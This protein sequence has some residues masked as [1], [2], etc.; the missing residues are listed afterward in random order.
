MKLTTAIA[1]SLELPSGKTGQIK[2][3][4]IVWDDD[5]PGFGVRL[6]AGRNGKV[7]R[8]W[9]YQYDFA[10]RTRRITIGNVNAIG[11]E[12]ARKIAGQHHADVRRGQDPVAEKAKSLARSG[13]IFADVLKTFL[14]VKK[15]TNR[16]GTYNMTRL[17]LNEPCKLLHPMSLNDIKRRHVAAILTTFAARGTKSA[18]NHVRGKLNTF[19]NWAITQGLIE[20][21]PVQG[22]EKKEASER[23]RVLSVAELVAVWRALEDMTNYEYALGLLISTGGYGH[24]HLVDDLVDYRDIV[25]MLMLTAARRSEISELPW[26]EVRTEESFID[27]GLPVAGP[28]LVLP[29]KRTKNE[30]KFIMHLSKPAQVVLQRHPRR[31]DNDQVFQSKFNGKMKYAYAW[32]RYKKL[33]DAALKKSG[34]QFEHWVLHDL[35]RSVATHMGEMDIQPHVIEEV[36]N[37]KTKFRAGVAGIYN[38]SR[39]EVPKRQALEAWGEHLMAHVEGRQPRDNVTPIRVA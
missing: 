10:G 15:Q 2:T 19:F 16:S 14:E 18:Y 8:M 25:Q 30:H 35:R 6:R 5:F 13:D 1:R 33:L 31:G 27:D 26:S 21:N 36:L 17:Y 28:A 37:H 34:H 24:A 20:T 23:T 11:I 32:S 12:E 22:T 29:P 3:D 39:L 4:H 9:I 38:K 7:S